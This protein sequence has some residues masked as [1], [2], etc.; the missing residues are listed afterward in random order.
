MLIL[1]NLDSSKVLKELVANKEN[2]QVLSRN[3][4]SDLVGAIREIPGLGWYV[5]VFKKEEDRESAIISMA[6][7]N[8]L[9]FFF[10]LLVTF[11]LASYSVRPLTE[12]VNKLIEQVREGKAVPTEAEKSPS[13]R[14]TR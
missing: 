6:A 8:S 12:S 3:D 11:I 5:G 7:T 2:A 4:A 13:S 10:L 9:I 1:R 14:R